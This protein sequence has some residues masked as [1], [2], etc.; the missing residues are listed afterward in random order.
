MFKP[1]LTKKPEVN[2]GVIST[3]WMQGSDFTLGLDIV[4]LGPPN[5][6]S[7]Y[8]KTTSKTFQTNHLKISNFSPSSFALIVFPSNQSFKLEIKWFE[9]SMLASLHYYS[10]EK[11]TEDWKWIMETMNA[12]IV[13]K[14]EL[15]AI[16]MLQRNDFVHFYSRCK[17]Q[18]K[19]T[20][21]T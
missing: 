11:L 5:W 8:C 21:S 13:Y 3:R 20:V 15:E 18:G 6:E 17:R 16:N 12:I 4:I 14:L 10:I 2:G 19:K 9:L 1:T 7:L